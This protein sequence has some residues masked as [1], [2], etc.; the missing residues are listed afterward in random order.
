M[1]ASPAHLLSPAVK[2]KTLLLLLLLLRSLSLSPHSRS[3]SILWSLCSAST[4]GGCD[5]HSE[6]CAHCIRSLCTVKST[7]QP[8]D[9]PTP[10][11][12]SSHLDWCGLS[13]CAINPIRVWSC[14]CVRS[15]KRKRQKTGHVKKSKVQN[16]RVGASP[17]AGYSCRKH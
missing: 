12:S 5:I 7:G 3:P 17:S 10:T 14:V 13:L 1:L 15:L 9:L 16:N 4:P 11:S 6:R 2:K 8:G